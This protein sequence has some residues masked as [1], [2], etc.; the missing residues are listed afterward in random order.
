MTNEPPWT[1]IHVF[2]RRVHKDD[3]SMN[4]RTL[5]S[6]ERKLCWFFFSFVCHQTV[7]NQGCG[8]CPVNQVMFSGKQTLLLSCFCLFFFFFCCCFFCFWHFE[9]HKLRVLS[10]SITFDT[11]PTA[12]WRISLRPDNLHQNNL[13]GWKKNNRWRK[14]YEFFILDWNCSHKT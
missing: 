11:R 4:T 14:K 3:S 1:L 12:L 10:S 7:Y 8:L 6:G 9:N 2:I 13:D 5:P